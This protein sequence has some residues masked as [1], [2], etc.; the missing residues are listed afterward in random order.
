MTTVNYIDQIFLYRGPITLLQQA[1]Y[2]GDRNM[3]YVLT[4]NYGADPMLPMKH[5]I[6]SKQLN[7]YSF[8]SL[9]GHRDIWFA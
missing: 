7:G 5:P 6:F 8:L 4:R 1:L 3:F 2:E 9:C